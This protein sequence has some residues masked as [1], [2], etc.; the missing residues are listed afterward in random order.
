M[1]SG[2]NATVY[3]SDMDAAVRFYS[4]TL[5]LTLT[6][7]FGNH[8]ATLEADPCYY[9]EKGAGLTIGLH[10]SSSKHADPG[11]AGGVG[12]GLETYEP[13]ERVLARLQDNGVRITSEI[14]RYNGGNCFQLLDLDGLPT[15]VNEFPPD[16]V[17]L[18][19]L[20]GQEHT[21]KVSPLGT[22]FGGH[23]IV[24]V[25]NMNAGVRF[26]SEKLGLPLTNRY[27][28]HFATVEA[29]G[30]VLAIHPKTPR[31]PDP[32]KKGSVALGLQVDEPIERVV[33][34]LTERGVRMTGESAPPDAGA[35][36][37]LEDEDGNTIYLWEPRAASARAA[38]SR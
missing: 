1:I 26:Y 29:G 30:L 21:P 27:G 5:G 38:A 9:S 8:W 34:R 11:T 37:E 24:Y 13:A 35:R 15:Y 20:G 23:A 25:S 31:T 10:P 18:T 6:N 22:R 16:M 7:R 33:S 4:E 17:P 28:D 36:V 19:D 2:G 3:V 12:F 32:G 14:I